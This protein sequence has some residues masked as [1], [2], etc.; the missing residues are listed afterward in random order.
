MTIKHIVILISVATLSCAI[1]YSI[2]QFC[3]GSCRSEK[4]DQS[5]T[6]Q[7]A[8]K[9]CTQKALKN[10]VFQMDK[11]YVSQYRSLC[12]QLCQKRASISKALADSSRK[13]PLLQQWIKESHHI[14]KEME[15]V[16]L[17]HILQIRDTLPEDKKKEFIADIQK[18]LE[19][20][21]QSLQ[22][23]SGCCP[24]GSDCKE[25]SSK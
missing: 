18:E 5:S 20:A 4:R 14:M 2:T 16:T 11:L 22:L 23:S 1:G 10:K 21:N 25:R 15:T 8:I 12:S 9:Y 17:D 19:I 6:V 3:I 24:S 7:Y 13:D